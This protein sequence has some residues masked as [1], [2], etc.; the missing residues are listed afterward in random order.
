MLSCGYVLWNREDNHCSAQILNVYL[1]KTNSS[2]YAPP[3]F[4]HNDNLVVTLNNSGGV[5]AVDCSGFLHFVF[6]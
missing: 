5:A 2:G 6:F 3:I 4:D 1:V